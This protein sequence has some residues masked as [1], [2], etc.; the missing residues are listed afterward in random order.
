MEKEV[1]ILA[2]VRTNNFTDDALQDKIRAVWHTAREK[3]DGGMLY[4]IY[5]DYESDYRGDYTLSVATTSPIGDDIIALTQATYTTYITSAPH[6]FDTWESIWQ[7]ESEGS[8]NRAYTI[9]FERYL[10]DGR[11]EIFVAF[12]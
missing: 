11:V 9:D 5:H 2:S 12:K 3:N 1:Y 7:R 6:I 8:I 10:E 4:G